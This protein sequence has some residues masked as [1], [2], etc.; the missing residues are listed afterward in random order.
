MPSLFS[1]LSIRKGS[2]PPSGSKYGKGIFSSDLSAGSEDATQLSTVHSLRQVSSNV[3]LHDR[4]AKQSSTSHLPQPPPNAHDP[5]LSE[6]GVPPPPPPSKR[7]S[8]GQHL[9]SATEPR[10]HSLKRV[11]SSLST[12]KQHAPAPVPSSS[13]TLAPPSPPSYGYTTIG[14]ESQ[15]EV[16]KAVEVVLACG[17][18]IRARGE[19]HILFLPLHPHS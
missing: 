12:R 4:G 16:S 9:R 10:K 13:A 2:K 18:Q 7:A 14:W 17:E 11:T 19:R 8:N 5:S 1:R 3:E 6:F 15:M